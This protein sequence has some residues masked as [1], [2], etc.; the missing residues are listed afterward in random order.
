MREGVFVSLPVGCTH[1]GWDWSRSSG[2]ICQVSRLRVAPVSRLLVKG[3]A[4][5]R[6][7]LSAHVMVQR[8]TEEPGSPRGLQE[9]G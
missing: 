3:R 2:T 8:H 4:F 7:L 9:V 6:A 1:M 5:L